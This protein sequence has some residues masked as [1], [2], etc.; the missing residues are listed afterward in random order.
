LWQTGWAVS[1]KMDNYLSALYS[2]LAARR[3]GKRAVIAVAHAILVIAYHLLKYKEDY[4]ELGAD[5]FDRLHP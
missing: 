1:T 5:Y 2:S 3:G 4:R